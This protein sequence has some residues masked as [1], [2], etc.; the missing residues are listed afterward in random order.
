MNFLIYFILIF[1][2][3]LQE[4][5]DHNGNN[6]IEEQ[7]QSN[8]INEFDLSTECGEDSPNNISLNKEKDE[9]LW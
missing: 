3:K 5:I 8:N 9:I 6:L 7:K 4:I 2:L 1:Q